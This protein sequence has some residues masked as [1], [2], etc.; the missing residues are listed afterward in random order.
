MVENEIWKST[1]QQIILL[2]DK[3]A[4]KVSSTSFIE[5]NS[6]E[7]RLRNP[8]EYLVKVF[9]YDHPSLGIV[10]RTRFSRP[11]EGAV[12][13]VGEEGMP[14]MTIDYETPKEA[15]ETLFVFI[16]LLFEEGFVHFSVQN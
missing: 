15:E 11:D 16:D 10:L 14:M 5:E 1:F 7:V 4:D 2:V 9:I 6:L 13:K 12:V 8:S 3:Y